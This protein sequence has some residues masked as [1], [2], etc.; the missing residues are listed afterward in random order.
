[1]PVATRHISQIQLI[2]VPATDQARSVRFYELLG[3][4]KRN[5]FPFGEGH[6]WIELYLP[7][8]PTGITITTHRPTDPIGVATGLLL[9]T[10]DI[11]V[12]HAFLQANGVDVDPAVARPGSPNSI[13][14]GAV[15][16]VGP[17]PPMFWLRDPDGN[18]LLVVE[19]HLSDTE[20]EDQS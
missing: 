11:G 7:E 9:N 12:T 1:M 5:D 8:S 18:T 13:L 17:Q 2:M 10:A 16:V 6:R 19:P 20:N 3:F 15:E 4:E 14:L